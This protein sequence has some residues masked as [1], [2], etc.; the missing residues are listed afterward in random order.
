MGQIKLPE[1]LAPGEKQAAVESINNYLLAAR[2]DIEASYPKYK[3]DVRML[4]IYGM[5]YNGVGDAARGEEVLEVAHTIAPNKQLVAFDLI[6]SYLIQQKFEEAYKLGRETY[7]LSIDCRDALKWFMI[8]AAYS[9]HYKEAKAYVL[10]KGQDPG[11]DPDVIAGV[12]NSG[13]KSVA[14]ELLQEL[15]K[16]DPTVAS[17]VDAYIRQLINSPVAPKQ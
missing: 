12:V 15:K 14:I 16:K 9:G 3:E 10:S 1:T 11:V 5:F 13:Q 8:P 7:D 4:S 17:Q 2:N 6:R